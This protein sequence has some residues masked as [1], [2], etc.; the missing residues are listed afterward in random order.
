MKHLKMYEKFTEQDYS[1]AKKKREQKGIQK[2]GDKFIVDIVEN[3]DFDGLNYLLSTGYNLHESAP[4]ENLLTSAIRNNQ[5]EMVDYLL[6]IN[7]AGDYENGINSISLTDLIGE[8][9]YGND[10]NYVTPEALEWLKTITK[11]GFEFYDGSHNLIELYLTENNGYIGKNK[12]GEN[13][14]DIQ[15]IS[16]AEPFIDWLLENYPENY[17][18]CKKF[19]SDKLKNK[20]DYMEEAN[21]YNV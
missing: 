2:L 11:Y 6:K 20:Y 19:L 16:G 15:F 17:P 5:L 10:K 3:G 12:N 1:N 4:N 18:Y 7:Y 13:I 14:Y 9:K 8:K 21:K